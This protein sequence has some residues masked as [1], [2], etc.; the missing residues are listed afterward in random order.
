MAPRRV[1]FRGLTASYRLRP[2]WPQAN[3]R[4]SWGWW[5]VGP[6]AE[7]LHSKCVTQ[8]LVLLAMVIS[9]SWLWS[10]SGLSQGS[11]IVFAKQARA[12]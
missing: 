6:A 9:C 3:P 7:I 5:G 4:S 12:I 11:C 8:H 10:S 1:V 2:G